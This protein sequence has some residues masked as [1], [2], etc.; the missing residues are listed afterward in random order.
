[1]NKLFLFVIITFSF[2]V[3]AQVYINPGV[4]T[5]DVSIKSA[6]Q[7][8]SKYVSE[9]KGKKLPDF[10]K[11]WSAED[12]KKYKIPDPGVYGIGGDY[13]TYSMAEIKTIYYAKPL[14]NGTVL[15]KT[16]GGYTD[17]L[18]N[19]NV[20]YI[21]TNFIA[22]DV[23][24]QLYFIT[25]VEHY[26]SGW[27]KKKVR[28]I[29]FRY[30]K[31]HAFNK[32]KADNLIK[33]VKNLEKQWNLQPIEIE[34]FFAD[35]YEEI[36][37]IRGLEFTMGLGNRDKPSGIANQT[38][39]IIY[40]AGNGEN[41]FHEVVHIYLNRIHPK[42]PLNEG[43]AVYYGGSMG[44]P[45][46]WHTVKLKAYLNSHKEIDLNKFEDF[47]SMDNYTNPNS[48]IQ[49]ILCNVVFKKDGMIGLKRL[50]AY[51]NMNQVFEKEF[52]FN[53]TNLNEQLRELINNQ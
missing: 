3:Q 22:K 31:N 24:Q 13:P 40:C 45:L 8:Y 2:K 29:T 51:E 28:N 32:E 43:L 5:T 14:K 11:Y 21:S 30:Q 6:I 47:W 36:Q 19:L 52:K 15:L 35:T 10:A 18:K 16:T 9:F 27:Q 25:P 4:D 37:L 20:L 38:D 41:Y 46:Q 34:Y 12:C 26:K 44:K 23:K 7:F 50:L 39:N 49:G 48:T 42:S 33:Q 17:S 53:L 1:M